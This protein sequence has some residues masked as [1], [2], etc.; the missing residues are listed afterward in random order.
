MSPT[1]DLTFVSDTVAGFFAIANG[2]LDGSVTNI[3]NGKE[4]AMG[5]L[6]ALVGELMNTSISVKQVEDR[7]RPANSEVTRL[8]GDA[9]QLR[10]A[11]GWMPEVDLRSGLLKTIEWL[12][13]EF[14][15]RAKLSY[16]V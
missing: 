10:Q 8:M 3:S 1:R 13:G 14:D 11:M 6:V 7:T 15:S 5:Q 12:C 9:T 16:G 4:I 2:D